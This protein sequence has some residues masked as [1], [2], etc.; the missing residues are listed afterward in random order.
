MIL[1]KFR[2]K[3]SNSELVWGKKTSYKFW[4]LIKK[5]K[6]CVH[7]CSWCFCV[8]QFYIYV[9]LLKKVKNCY[10]YHKLRI[11]VVVWLNILLEEILG[12]IPMRN[13]FFQVCFIRFIVVLLIKKWNTLTQ[14]KPILVLV[15]CTLDFCSKGLRF[16]P[17]AS[18][19]FFKFVLKDLL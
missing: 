11:G 17:C 1:E 9:Y 15:V 14:H 4:L 16:N 7:S 5:R 10:F 3:T 13:I 8:A 18:H 19:F 12:S 6:P 2:K